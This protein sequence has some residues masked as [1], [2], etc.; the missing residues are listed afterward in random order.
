MYIYILTYIS[1][2]AYIYIYICI[3]INLYIYI[4]MYVCMYIYATY[5]LIEHYTRWYKYAHT[6]TLM[7]ARIYARFCFNTLNNPV[8]ELTH[9]F[10]PNTFIF[11]LLSGH[12]QDT[13]CIRPHHTTI[14]HTETRTSQRHTYTI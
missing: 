9:D 13:H 7:H 4:C 3:T 6:H 10:C 5:S 12:V 1:I 11:Q 14:Q 8:Y 2:Y